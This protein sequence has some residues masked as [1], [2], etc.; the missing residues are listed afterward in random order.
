MADRQDPDPRWAAAYEGVARVAFDPNETRR[1]RRIAQR[2]LASLSSAHD[3]L[4][5]YPPVGARNRGFYGGD[6]LHADATYEGW[7]S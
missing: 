5:T 6:A 4:H 1:R 2:A 3:A 7:G